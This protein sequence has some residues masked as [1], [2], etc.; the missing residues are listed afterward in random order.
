MVY[1]KKIEMVKFKHE[2]FKKLYSNLHKTYIILF[3][4]SYTITML[5]DLYSNMPFNGS[6]GD[7]LCVK[8]RRGLG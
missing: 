6:I 3:D 4:Q 8:K 5:E 1:Y 7:C 2:S